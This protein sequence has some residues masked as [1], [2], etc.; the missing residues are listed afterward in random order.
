MCAE[1]RYVDP[2]KKSKT[3]TILKGE[4]ELHVKI[5]AFSVEFRYLKPV[6]PKY[7]AANV[8]FRINAKLGLIKMKAA[9]IPK[10]EI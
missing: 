10:I 9:C 4:N 3:F 8:R 6:H 5:T 1:N 7:L 2:E